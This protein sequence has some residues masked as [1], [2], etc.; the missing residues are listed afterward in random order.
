MQTATCDHAIDAQRLLDWLY[1]EMRCRIL[2]LAA[3]FDRLQRAADGVAVLRRDQRLVELRQCIRLLLDDHPDRA[4]R[5]QLTLS[6]DLP[7]PST[8]ES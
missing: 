1:P 6:D 2:S 8:R 5:V 3:D 7:S 4:A